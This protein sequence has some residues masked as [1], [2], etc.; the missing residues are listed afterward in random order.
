LQTLYTDWDANKHSPPAELSQLINLELLDISSSNLCGPTLP[1]SWKLLTKLKSLDISCVNSYNGGTG[2]SSGSRS[3]PYAWGLMGALEQLRAVGAGLAGSLDALP[4]GNGSLPKLTVLLLENN[5]G[6]SGMLPPSW[7]QLPLQVLSLSN[8]NIQGSL[9]A[10][11]GDAM[12]N[13]ILRSTLQQLFLHRTRIDGEIPAAWHTGFSNV[14][15]FTVWGSNVCGKH[16]VAASGLG[17]LCLDTSG[18]RLGEL[19][20]NNLL[21]CLCISSTY[22]FLQSGRFARPNF[23][24]APPSLQQ[25]FAAPCAWLSL[26]CMSV[27]R[28]QGSTAPAGAHQ[29]QTASSQPTAHHLSSTTPPPLHLPTPH[30]H[31]PSSNRTTPLTVTPCVPSKQR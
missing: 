4:V 10:A 22:T 12:A 17:S 18:T 3:I 8:T 1:T 5:W 9:P 19:L 16:P 30:S 23:T 26:T 7:A 29:F 15:A 20:V 28:V 31:H 2:G 14:T 11:W 13:S 21:L 24:C 25:P 27:S 6:L